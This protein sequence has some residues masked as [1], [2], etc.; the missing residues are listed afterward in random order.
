MARGGVDEY[1][2]VA[3]SVEGFVQQLAVSYLKNHYWL[4]VRGEVPEGK[5]PERVDE[6]LLA[7]Y[8]I[9]VSKWSRARA[10]KRGDARLQY[11][12]YRRTFLLLS[13]LSARG[14]PHP[15]FEAEERDAIK[16][17]RETP[18]QFYGY[19]VSYK[20]GHPHV[21]IAE[22]QFRVLVEA[23]IGSAL[24]ASAEA[25]AAW[26]VALPFEPYAPVK[27]QLRRLLGKVNRARRTA[28]LDKVPITCLRAN[29]LTVRPFGP[30]DE[31]SGRSDRTPPSTS[32]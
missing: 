4:Y 16:D 1:R 30:A 18:I 15:L 25:L 14:R 12:R 8:P 27:L 32:E 5:D 26:V 24:S 10:K 9:A 2:Y 6:K 31:R 28:G 23:F 13:T 29:R 20:D 22:A 3:T 17:A 7:K 21:R 11:L 19:S